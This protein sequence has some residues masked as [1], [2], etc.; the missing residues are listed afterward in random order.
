MTMASFLKTKQGQLIAAIVALIALVGAVLVFTG[1]GDSGVETTDDTVERASTTTTVPPETTTTLPIVGIAPLTGLALTDAAP[2]T[3]PA[4]FVKID[5]A[6][7]KGPPQSGLEFA[8]IVYEFQVEGGVT[9]LGAAFHSHAPAPIGPVRSLRFSEVG[10]INELG[11]PMTV[12]HGQNT[13]VGPAAIAASTMIKTNIDVIP[14]LFYREPSKPAPYNS[15]LQGIQPVFDRAP[16]GTPPPPAQFLF[17]DD[18]A[19]VLS[20]E[21]VPVTSVFIGFPNVFGNGATGANSEFRWNG[22]KFERFQYGAPHL[23]ASGAQLAYDNVVVRFVQYSDSGTVDTAGGVVVTA[24]TAGSGDAWIAS[25]GKIVQGRWEKADLNSPTRYFDGA[26][27][28]MLFTRGQ[29]WVALPSPGASS[30]S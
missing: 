5:N 7:D 21:A 9:R 13:I 22:E 12:W 10:I 25:Q 6:K 17:S 23:V 26:G 24:E 3:R 19:T 30:I 29:T 20:P 1:G 16:E 11:T 8:D 14:D 15:Y 27:N 4:V 18:P 2:L 28:E